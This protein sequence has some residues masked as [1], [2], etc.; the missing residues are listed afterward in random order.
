ML[1]LGNNFQIIRSVLVLLTAL[2]FLR[3]DCSICLNK[4]VVFQDLP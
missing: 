2:L 1:A 4:K 3:T